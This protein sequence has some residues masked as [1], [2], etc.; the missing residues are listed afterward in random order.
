MLRWF[1]TTSQPLPYT[2]QCPIQ[3]AG[4]LSGPQLH[5]KIKHAVGFW[6]G[7]S[8]IDPA[9]TPPNTLI[10]AR[11]FRFIVGGHPELEG[12]IKLKRV[13]VETT[14]TQAAIRRNHHL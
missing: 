8:A 6:Y 10:G 3:D 5:I 12:V 11:D 13:F 7:A 4:R 2:F 1:Q 9:Y 14:T